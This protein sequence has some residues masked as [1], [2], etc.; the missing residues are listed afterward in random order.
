MSNFWGAYHI[1]FYSCSF[2]LYRGS[3]K[4]SMSFGVHV[5]GFG[6]SPFAFDLSNAML[7][8]GVVYEFSAKDITLLASFFDN[9]GLFAFFTL[10]FGLC[11]LRPLACAVLKLAA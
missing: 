9:C 11:R 6:L 3:P 4:R 8:F 7:A 5:Y 2:C 1:S 10:R